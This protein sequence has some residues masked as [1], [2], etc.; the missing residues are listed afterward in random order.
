[1][2]G[3]IVRLRSGDR[4]PADVRLIEA[5]NLRIEESALTGESV[6][7]EKNTE[8]AAA[9]AGVGDRHGMA[10][11][12]TMVA[13]GR[14]VG[15][16][17]ATG[18]GHRTRPHQQMISEVETLATPLTRQ[19]NRFG[20]LLSVVIV[21]LATLMFV[22]GWRCTTS[23]STNF[24]WPPSAS[25]SPPSPRVCRRSS[26]S[27]WPSGCSAWPAQRHH[28][29]AQRGG[30][31]G[32]GDGDL[33]RQDRHADPQRDDGAPCGH[34]RRRY[35][36]EG[37]GY[38]PE[39]SI[40]RDDEEAAL[41]RHPDLCA[42]IEVMAVANDSDI[43]EEDGQWKVTGEPTEGALRTL[44]RK[45]AFDTEG[46]RTR[47]GDSLRVGQQVHGH[48]RP[49]AGGG[50]RILL[51]GAPDR[52]LE[53]CASSVGADGGSEAARPRFWDQHIEGLGKRGP[54]RAGRRCARRG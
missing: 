42:L 41:D 12:G 4:V 8:P 2:P 51:K 38:A 24:S 23:P 54:A 31:P 7:S 21:G 29:Q 14:G 33:L 49:G 22:A 1:V 28:P 3:D 20:K 36:V 45:A 46:L 32:L 53:R 35:D 50:A 10:Y 39:G 16:V 25:L 48:P 27:R 40:T 19:M 18:A 9:D 5:V 11:S 30:D 52:L 26:P 15:V 43:S 17:T 44:A 34:P 47:G 13:A 37:T 6:P